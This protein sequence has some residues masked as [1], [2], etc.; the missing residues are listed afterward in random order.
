MVALGAT[1][2]LAAAV[3]HLADALQT[4]C[5]FVLRCY[6]VTVAPLI[7][8]CTLLWGVGLGGSYLLAYRG[9]GPWPA[10][11]SPLAFWL[12]SAL[13]L[14]LTALPVPRAAV[15]DGQATALSAAAPGR[16]A[17]RPGTRARSASPCPPCFRCAVRRR[18]AARRA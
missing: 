13:A 18:A 10:M 8:Y 2:L 7:L 3:Y 15:A 1:L 14:A 4:L 16:S 17:R 11:Q 12:M 9:I 6:R 5:V